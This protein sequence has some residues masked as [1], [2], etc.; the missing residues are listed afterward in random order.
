MT[1]RDLNLQPI[2][3]NPGIRLAVAEIKSVKS[4]VKAEFW[5]EFEF[6]AD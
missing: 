4:V 1:T 2:Q 6:T 5:G 3:G